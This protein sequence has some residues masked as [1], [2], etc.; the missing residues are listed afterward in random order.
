MLGRTISHYRIEEKLG[1]GG[2]GIVYRATDLSLKRSVAIKFLSSEVADEQHRRRFQQEAQTAS[3]L[4]HPHILTVFE[5]GTIDGQQYLVTEFIDGSTLREW[6]RHT[7]PSTK[8]IVELLIGIA[9]AL[10]TA[11]E[12]GI[13]HRDVKP[14]N[15]LVAKNGYAK[16]VDFGLAKILETVAVSD[17]EAATRTLGPTRP[18]MILGTVAYMSPEQAGGRRVDAR[19]D[20]F[21]FGV[22]LYELLGGRRPF[23]GTSDVDV[24]HAILH[25]APR[26]LAELR[27]EVPAELRVAV[28]KALEKDPADR[29]QSMREMVVDLKRAQRRKTTDLPPPVMQPRPSWKHWAP[30]MLVAAVSLLAG[31]VVGWFLWRT[32][33]S[34]ENLFAKAQISRLTDFEGVELDA[35]I[36]ADGKLVAFLADRDGPFDVWV[37][38]VGTGE[39]RNLTRGRV[40]DLLLQEVRSVGFS[41]DGTHVWF[42]AGEKLG[43][44]LVPAMG[45][46]ARPFLERAVTAS[47]S[48]DGSKIAYHENTPG[49]PIFI[50]DRNGGNRR[51]IFV[52]KP[53]LHC[54]YPAW[55]PD[56]RFVY[57]V[58]GF[59]PNEMDIWRISASGG[60]PER[61]THHNSR[62][63]DGALLDDR[64]LVYTATAEDGSGPWLYW[65][66]VERRKTR[67]V[68]FGVEQYISIAASAALP[69]Q[70]L[71][72]VASVS[73][74]VSTLWQLP[75]LDQ[76]AEESAATRFS[77]PTMRGLVPRFGPDFLL[78]LSSTGG[79][80]GL[81]KLKDGS[82]TELWKG[83]EG[84]VTVAPAIS[85]DGRQ[86]CFSFRKQG[87]GRL[88]C[89]TIDGTNVRPLAESL[90]VRGAVS[91]SPD[92]K[93][94][95]VAAA[96]AEGTRVYKVPVDGGSPVRLFN[97]LSANPLWSPDGQMIVYTEPLQ[98]ASYP[99]K[100]I[101]PEGKTF[102]LPE[103]W[104]R[105]GGD[106]Y[107]FL[108]DGRGMVLLHGG[109]RQQNFWLLD[110]A[111]SHMRQL[112]NLRPGFSVESFD[113]SPGGKQIIFDRVRENSDL[114]LIE[115]AH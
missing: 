108:P 91:W 37:T 115:L 29:H 9:D 76:V 92:A 72:L 27:A 90:D 36:S 50:A 13:L 82:A 55:S 41:G 63:A 51:R 49:D 62:I 114:V 35:A 25:N 43:I 28:E 67:R 99:V 111:N 18:G 22:V 80:D 24:M 38:Q 97:G 53:G 105:I 110:F 113:I 61:I 6:A 46:V 101:T 69:G 74:P 44:S 66:D 8:Q 73:N 20:I 2:M 19:S 68:S 79:A 71:R 56:G 5:V 77:L 17:A 83:G 103:L 40:A 64:T 104:V 59:S 10:A 21:S 106:R 81:W 4:N 33:D 112:T 84:A 60:E 65:I 3:S 96:D 12:A 107:R 52:E 11:H 58:R 1:E 42:R 16:L 30:I 45:G 98:G 109:F 87:R 15:I 14:E 39:F 93:W 102:P 32:G 34:A 47:W 75:I 85:P 7:Q 26:S 100:A 89:M 57:F 88:H 95:V 78:Y 31:S 94:V 70:R 86:V 23:G 54:H 48:P